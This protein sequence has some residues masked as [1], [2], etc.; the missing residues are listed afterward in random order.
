MAKKVWYTYTIALRSVLRNFLRLTNHQYC[1]EI[2]KDS[3]VLRGSLLF[4]CVL[5]GLCPAFAQT[6]IPVGGS[7]KVDGVIEPK[8][9][10]DAA[11]FAFA[12]SDIVTA[13]V[14]A[15]HDGAHLLLAYIYENPKDSTYI[16]PE[17][18][19]DTKFTKGKIWGQDDFWFHVSAQDCF[20]IGKR[21]DYSLCSRDDAPWK[22]VPNYPYGDAYKKIDV[23][24]ISVPFELVK[25]VPGQTVGICFSIAIFPGE[26]RLNHPQS[27]HEDVP[28]TWMAISIE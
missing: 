17:F 22:A 24:E 28:E 12:K 3:S 19:I 8:E 21:E 6:S 20:A 7:I 18:F 11:S 27:S 5:S 9:W 2:M 4:L 14:F 13:K 23:F 1:I 15:K 16:L 26:L 10:N 25:V